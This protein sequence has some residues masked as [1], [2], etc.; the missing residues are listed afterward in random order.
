LFPDVQYI[1]QHEQEN[2]NFVCDKNQINQIMV[3]I[4]KN[5]EE[6]MRESDCKKQIIEIK[7]QEENQNI[8]ITVKD[9]GP[10]FSREALDNA[11]EAYFTTRA[12]GTGLGLAIVKK[13]AQDHCGEIIISNSNDKNSIISGSVVEIKFNTDK[14]NQ[15]FYE[16]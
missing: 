2:I 4:L 12:K 5:A 7:I 16:N 15:K 10:G 6:A 11:T 1:F 14:L 9:N 3:N 8:K 13:I